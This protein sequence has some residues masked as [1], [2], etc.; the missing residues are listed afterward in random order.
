MQRKLEREFELTPEQALATMQQGSYVIPRSFSSVSETSSFIGSYAEHSCK[1]TFEDSGEAHLLEELE[2]RLEVAN[3][4]E[5]EVGS[6][7]KSPVNQLLVVIVVAV[8]LVGIFLFLGMGDGKSKSESRGESGEE[9]N[10]IQ[11]KV[12]SLFNVPDDKPLKPAVK[13]LTTWIEKKKIHK[14]ARNRI[15]TIYIKRS[16]TVLQRAL[17]LS[18]TAKRPRKIEKFLLVAIAFN[19]RNE[20]AWR[21]LIDHY[22][23]NG[24]ESKAAS[25]WQRVKKLGIEID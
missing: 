19:P 7:R 24:Q 16:D 17:N 23:H 20:Q 4:D 10:Y 15:S 5:V 22:E 14:A 3:E 2:H 11:R 1:L 12:T 6:E 25:A 21:K 18:Q 13:Q 8:L 9:V